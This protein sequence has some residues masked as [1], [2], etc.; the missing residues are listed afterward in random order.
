MQ[1]SISHITKKQAII[2]KRPAIG[3]PIK[4]KDLSKEL[5]D[6]LFK[7]SRNLDKKEKV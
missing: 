3:I 2:A 1:K 5:K 4:V 7:K 6:F